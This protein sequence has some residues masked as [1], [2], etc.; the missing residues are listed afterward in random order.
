MGSE[1]ENMKEICKLC[2]VRGRCRP[3]LNK[4]W[5]AMKYAKIAACMRR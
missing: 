3:G 2:P 5:I 1:G 4:G